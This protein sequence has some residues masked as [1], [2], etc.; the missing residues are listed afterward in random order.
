VDKTSLYLPDE[1]HREL[2]MAARRS[3]R[4]QAELI[5]VALQEYL[6]G[7]SAPKLSSI[8]AGKDTDLAGRDTEE[9]L[10]GE[11]AAR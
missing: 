10:E 2:Q 4:P 5:R 3:G 11:W 9:W 7:M 8:G 1:L 6:R